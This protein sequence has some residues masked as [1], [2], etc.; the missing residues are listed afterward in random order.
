MLS[1]KFSIGKPGKEITNLSEL[2]PQKTNWEKRKS[3]GRIQIIVSYIIG[4][5][6][7]EGES[8]Y[9]TRRLIGFEQ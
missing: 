1:F 5:S 9:V 2:K 3:D 7:D 8:Q 6:Y 4:K